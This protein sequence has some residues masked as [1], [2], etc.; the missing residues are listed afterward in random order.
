MIIE[1]IC[2][3][4]RRYHVQKN[5]NPQERG[6]SSCENQDGIAWGLGSIASAPGVLSLS[7]VEATASKLSL[8]APRLEI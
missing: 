8:Y 1:W 3:R 2:R 7:E 6:I 5:I 4:F